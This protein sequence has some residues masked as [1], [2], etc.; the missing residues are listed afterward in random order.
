MKNMITRGT[1]G[2]H[3][4]EMTPFSRSNDFNRLMNYFWNYFETAAENNSGE[5]EPHLQIAESKD[6]VTVTAE[7]P[8]INERDVE[9]Q[10]SSDGYLTVCGEKK[11]HSETSEKDAY[12]SE[13]TYGSFRR[14]IPLPWDLDYENA[15][16]HYNNGVL[17]VTIPKSQDEKQKFKKIPIQRTNN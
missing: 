3:N 17:T 8:G 9:L 14:T 16:A 1:C 4:Q 10:I 12:F 13:I 5:W 15:A 7:L 2:N 6:S 11:N